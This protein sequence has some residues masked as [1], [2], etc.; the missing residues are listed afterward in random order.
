MGYRHLDSSV[1]ALDKGGK[2][3]DRSE[4]ED[5]LRE[6]IFRHLQS[7]L[8]L[9][10]IADVAFPHDIF[11]LVHQLI[12]RLEAG[13]LVNAVHDGEDNADITVDVK[14]PQENSLRG[15]DPAENLRQFETSFRRQTTL[16]DLFDT[17]FNLEEAVRFFVDMVDQDL[18]SHICSSP[19]PDVIRVGH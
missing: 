5:V 16:C 1:E 4:L 6:N 18:P 7:C 11:T 15:V 13:D 9:G 8:E 12:R 14:K 2:K 3:E 10:G 17:T 19:A